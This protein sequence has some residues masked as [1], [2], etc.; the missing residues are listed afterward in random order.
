[1]IRV[2]APAT[3]KEGYQFDVV[4]ENEPYTVTV[5]KGG[6]EEGEQFEVPYNNNHHHNNTTTMPMMYRRGRSFRIE[7]NDRFSLNSACDK[8]TNIY[9]RRSSEGTYENKILEKASSTSTTVGSSHDEEEDN[10]KNIVRTQQK[11]HNTITKDLQ[12]DDAMH[13]T[14]EKRSSYMD[15]NDKKNKANKETTVDDEE[16]SY[17]DTESPSNNNDIIKDDEDSTNNNDSPRAI[18]EENEIVKGKWRNGLF[19]CCNV[20]TQ[21]TFWMSI[22]CIPVLL[23]Q[24]ITRLHLNCYGQTITVEKHQS[25]IV[26]TTD[27]LKKKYE[28]SS[29]SYNKIL[30]SFITVLLLANVLPGIGLLVIAIYYFG[31]CMIYI[32]TNVRNSIRQRYQIP[33]S[34]YVR[35]CNKQQQRSD[36]QHHD[37][38]CEDCICMTCCGCCTLIQMARHTHDD[39]EYPG[40]CC[41]TTGLEIG[42]PEITMT[43]D[44]DV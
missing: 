38:Y 24:I 20:L 19:Q 9:N 23:A 22:F 35:I 25:R 12:D 39:K 40:Y 15:C 1:M 10:R 36:G 2:V 32:G 7:G 42:A 31:Y 28:I 33:S 4:V 27:E 16:L 18:D 41:T 30:F 14:T 21:A 5:P 44:N 17:A 43:I 13:A 26:T 8:S 3:L 34:S 6:V 11:N 37:S 29:L